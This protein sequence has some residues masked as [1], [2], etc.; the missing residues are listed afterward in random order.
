MGG[1]QPKLCEPDSLLDL[2]GAGAADTF[3]ALHDPLLTEVPRLLLGRCQFGGQTGEA[4]IGK[5][6]FQSFQ[7]RAVLLERV[8]G[9]GARVLRQIG[10]E[11]LARGRGPGGLIIAGGLAILATEF[12]WAKRALQN[13][14][15]AV[16]KAR[17][18]GGWL[19]WLRRRKP[20]AVKPSPCAVNA[21]CQPRGE[22][23]ILGQQ[24]KP[25]PPPCRRGAG[26]R[27]C[28]TSPSRRRLASRVPP[29]FARCAG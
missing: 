7:P 1:I 8:A 2:A 9:D 13:A 29:R 6:L 23:V 17:R 19:A 10:F 28:P 4:P 16:A 24:G 22:D 5:A 21:I 18:K 14:K 12:L 11:L 25:H 3:H 27:Y 15:G 26:L 20:A